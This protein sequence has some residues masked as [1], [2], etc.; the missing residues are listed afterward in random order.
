[1]RQ[2]PQSLCPEVLNRLVHVGPVAEL[3]VTEVGVAA[4][5]VAVDEGDIHSHPNIADCVTRQQMTHLGQIAS[6]RVL[7]I[8][9]IAERECGLQLG[10]T[11]TTGSHV[12]V[13]G[14]KGGYSTTLPT[15]KKR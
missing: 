9:A 11:R 14:N 3:A 8:F 13:L 7:Q 4:G 15:V 12:H 5:L 1:M 10:G 6:R 2:D